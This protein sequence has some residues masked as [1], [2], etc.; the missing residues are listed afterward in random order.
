MTQNKEKIEDCLDWASQHLKLKLTDI[1]AFASGALFCQLLD[2]MY[3]GNVPLHKV[4]W[5]TEQKSDFLANF[6]ILNQSFQKYRIKKEYSQEALLSG[7]STALFDLLYW[8]KISGMAQRNLGENYDAVGRRE[9]QDFGTSFVEKLKSRNAGLEAV[10]STQITNELSSANPSRQPGAL[11]T[12]T[13]DS[14]T[15]KKLAS[16]DLLKSERDFYYSK[17]RDID[18]VLDTSKE[19]SSV[20]SLIQ[21]L[22]DIIYMTPDKIGVVTEE[23]KFMV[24]TQ[25]GQERK[26]ENKGI[27]GGA[28][29]SD[30]ASGGG[31]GVSRVAS[32]G[33]NEE[34]NIN[35]NFGGDMNLEEDI[36]LLRENN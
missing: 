6:D 26:G 19:T 23:G 22:K 18:Q 10:G 33:F 34:N 4:K 3:E 13:L 27:S 2:L 31:A 7:D 29:A 21:T 5:Q 8:F 32:G 17:I 36:D 1:E 16:Y 20:S 9:G 24:K 25:V 30:G 12:S 14:S 11:N 35:A 28:D 15:I